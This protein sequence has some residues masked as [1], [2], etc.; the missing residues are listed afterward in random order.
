[1]AAKYH[2]TTPVFRM[3]MRLRIDDRSFGLNVKRPYHTHFIER[4]SDG[5]RG[6]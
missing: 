2:L 3:T 5:A 1:M 6:F 4:E